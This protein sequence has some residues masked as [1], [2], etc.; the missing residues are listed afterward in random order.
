MEHP[1][2]ATENYGDGEHPNGGTLQTMYR[3]KASSR[4]RGHIDVD[5][6]NCLA[7]RGCWGEPL[8]AGSG[9][10]VRRHDFLNTGGRLICQGEP[11]S[12]VY[13]IVSGC[14]C[15]RETQRDGA[16]RIVG[17]RVPGELVG[18]EGWAQGRFTYTAEAAETTAVCRLSWPG[19]SGTHG[20]S[21]ALLQ[22]LLAKAAA[23]LY[24]SAPPWPGL[25]AAER[26]AAFLEDFAR[27]VRAGGGTTGDRVRLPMTRAQLG[28]YLGLAEETVVRALAQ[29][30]AGKRLDIKGRS[31]VLRPVAGDAEKAREVG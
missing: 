15:L 17:F 6:A 16:E 31:V 11:F 5:C 13:L 27:R 9:F 26:V 29:L 21:N 24:S 10:I 30:R 7:S 12:G 1:H 20:P 2:V 8:T 22:R 3:G 23:Q 4:V 28:S 19:A 14:L 18:L 25:P